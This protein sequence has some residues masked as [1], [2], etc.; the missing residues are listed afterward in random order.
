MRGIDGIYAVLHD[1]RVVLT[2]SFY[3]PDVWAI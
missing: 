1:M 2:V 3:G